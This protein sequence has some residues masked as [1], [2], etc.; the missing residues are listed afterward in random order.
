M[1][2]STGNILIDSS[3]D[4]PLEIQIRMISYSLNTIYLLAIE[5]NKTL[6]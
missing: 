3:A 2:D 6:F 1:I 4:L 5:V